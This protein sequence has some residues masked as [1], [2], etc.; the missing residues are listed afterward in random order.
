MKPGALSENGQGASMKL[1]G[2]LVVAGFAFWKPPVIVNLFF[3]CWCEAVIVGFFTILKLFHMPIQLGEEAKT[4]SELC[5]IVCCMSWLGLVRVQPLF[6][7]GCIAGAE[8]VSGRRDL[9]SRHRRRKVTA[10]AIGR[11]FGLTGRVI[12]G[13]E[14]EKLMPLSALAIDGRKSQRLTR[15]LHPFILSAHNRKEGQSFLI[16]RR[17]FEIITK[18]GKVYLEL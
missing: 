15:E 8:P 1:V 5:L 3:L 9:P 14:L 18:R 16:K 2:N 4:K 7:C 17:S 10:Q 6:E 13:R 12:S 11:E